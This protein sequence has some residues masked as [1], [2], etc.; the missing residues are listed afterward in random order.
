MKIFIFFQLI[1]ATGIVSAST[2]Y[3]E[4]LDTVTDILAN[5]AGICALQDFGVIFGFLFDAHLQKFHPEIQN[6]EDY[7]KFSKTQLQLDIAYWYT[8]ISLTYA[9]VS[10]AIW[11]LYQKQVCKDFD[12]FYQV[13]YVEFKNYKAK[14]IGRFWQILV[15]DV[16]SILGNLYVIFNF[17]L[18]WLLKKCFKGQYKCCDCCVKGCHQC[19][20]V[21]KRCILKCADCLTSIICCCATSDRRKPQSQKTIEIEIENLETKGGPDDKDTPGKDLDKDVTI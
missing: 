21:L 4:K 10:G 8:V 16:N 20:K 15:K 11:T 13:D 12:N 17:S 7:L 19:F 3:I 9:L 5:M 2:F 18:I 6:S 14:G 1:T